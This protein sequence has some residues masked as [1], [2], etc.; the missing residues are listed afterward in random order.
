M[1]EE[2]FL[3]LTEVRKMINQLLHERYCIQS[4]LGRQ[5]GRRTFLASDLQ[6]HSPVVIKLLLFGPDFTWDD[7]KLFEREA[8]TLKALDHPLIPQYLDSFEVDT[9]LGKGFAL[10]QSYIEAR[11]LQDWIQAGRNFSE[12]DLRAIAK[13][14]LEILDYLHTHQPPVIHRDIKP[15]NILLGD[16]SGNSH[17]KVYLVDFGSVQTAAHS[18]TITVVGTYGYMPPEQ[19]GGKT[20]PASDLY[21]LGATLIYLLTRTHP[22]DLPSR[23]GCIRFEAESLASE[24]FQTWLKYL[25]QPDV[26]RRF[27][28]A[29]SAM[30][31]LQNDL[32][33]LQSFQ[34]VHLKPRDSRVVLTKTDDQL[35]IV[36]PPLRVGQK[37]R[38]IYS[39]LGLTV[40]CC[41]PL[42][43]GFWKPEAG[44]LVSPFVLW[45]VSSIWV[46]GIYRIFEKSQLSIDQR[47]ICLTRDWLG[48]K[49]RYL[50]P[51]K[52]IIKLERLHHKINNQN[53]NNPEIQYSGLYI[54]VGIQRYSL[55]TFDSI[56]SGV[57]RL[58]EVE[59]DWL[60]VELSDWLDLPIQTSGEVATL[61]N[62]SWISADAMNTESNS[63][64]SAS[65]SALSISSTP[66]IELSRISRPANALCTVNK[67]SETIEISAPA[68]PNFCWQAVGCFA[69]VLS[70][71]LLMG[72][73]MISSVAA[74][75]LGTVSAVLWGIGNR[76]NNRRQSTNIVLRID[77]H[78]ISLWEQFQ[79]E[80][81]RCLNKKARKTIHKLQLVYKIDKNGQSYHIKVSTRYSSN[82]LEDC[83]VIGNRSFWL[84]RI[85][86]EWLAHELSI[87]LKL[88][89][90]EVQVVENSA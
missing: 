46:H 15:S 12:E 28:S 53:A 41:S 27:K 40:F 36:I 19:F 71:V 78:D 2:L 58:T 64:D 26:N 44:L 70:V 35:Q 73:S 9:E 87:W 16:R 23:N 52:D 48:F 38:V 80:Q 24:Q 54:W 7:L 5:T 43:L 75:L 11:S 85:E 29:Q 84:S 81:W 65:E 3:S 67:S 45:I 90:T 77:R 89:V 21:S 76:L 8:E 60:A 39:A 13:E 57:H 17:G 33:T 66:P 14:L 42:L 88:P 62:Q 50:S 55:G 30:D 69:C 49:K 31:A 72:G 18:G 22:S 51:T 83:F 82:T 68:G 63:I 6:T 20:T 61:D 47:E 86:A 25:I 10:V 34:S 4:L 32:L 1:P 37:L 79:S 74:I 56:N 59:L